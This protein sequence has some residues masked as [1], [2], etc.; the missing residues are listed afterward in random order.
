MCRSIRP[1][2]NFTPPA[3]DDDV[4]AAALQFVRK[5]SGFAKP[6]Q[7]NAEA[8][9]RAVDE[10]AASSRRLLESLTTSASPRDRAVVVARAKARAAKRYAAP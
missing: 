2:Y 1:L 3:S 10:V 7:Q 4:T 9:E 6:S 5:I 8:F